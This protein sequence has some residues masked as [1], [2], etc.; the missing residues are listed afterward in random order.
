MGASLSA[1][2]EAGTTV[3]FRFLL[4]NDNLYLV[5]ERKDAT[6]VKASDFNAVETGD[7]S[8]IYLTKDGEKFATLYWNASTAKSNDPVIADENGVKS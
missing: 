8:V 3:T 5:E 7:S 6:P 4:D 1:T 2:N